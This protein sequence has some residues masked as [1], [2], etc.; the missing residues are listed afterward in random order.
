MPKLPKTLQETVL[1]ETYIKK[2]SE[3]DVERKIWVEKVYDTASESLKCVRDT[4]P[5]Y[6]LHDER[7]VLNKDSPLSM[8]HDMVPKALA[9]SACN[10]R[11]VFSV[12]FRRISLS[13]VSMCSKSNLQFCFLQSEATVSRQ[14]GSF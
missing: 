9:F 1:W 8:L 2:T 10:T 11:R 12:A 14:R 6:T 7:H 3:E 4:F 13:I 5:N